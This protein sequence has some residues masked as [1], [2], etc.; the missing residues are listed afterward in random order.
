[1]K[2]LRS[3]L[4]FVNK[5][6]NQFRRFCKRQQFVVFSVAL[7]LFF[8]Q[9]HAATLKG[10]V[11]DVNTREGLVGALVLINDSAR[12]NDITGLDGS[13]VLHNLHPG[14]YSI[15]VQYIGFSKLEQ[16]LH[17]NSETDNL[18]LDILLHQDS[19]TLQQV[20]IIGQVDRESDDF[21]RQSEKNSDN[22][23]N[24]MSAK[25]MQLSPDVTVGNVL[26]RVSGVTVEK[27]SSGEGR[28]A[29]IRGMDKRYNYT[30]INGVKIPSPDNKNRFV[31]MDIFPSEILERLEVIKS[32]AASMEGDAIGGAMNLVLKDAP[33][34][35]LLSANA[36]TGYN[37][38]LFDRSF[39]EFNTSVIHNQS[40]DQLYG[41]QYQAVNSDF[42]L[43]NY[44]YR[45]V[46]ALPNL[47][48]GV[49]IGNRFFHHK[50]GVL[51]SGNY[52]NSYSGTTS[53]FIA[54][55]AQPTF[56]PANGPAFSDIEARTYSLQQQRA[57]LHTKL[58][59]EISSGHK[60]SLYAL[61]VGLDQIRHR[62]ISDTIGIGNP[63]AEVDQHDESKVTYQNILNTSLHGEDSLLRNLQ[64]DWSLNW[65]KATANSPDWGT[66]TATGIAN[67][68]QSTWSSFTR[69]WISNSDRDLSAFFNLT[70]KLK[71]LQQNLELKGGWMDRNKARDNYYDSYD[72]AFAP[73]QLVGNI[74]RAIYS[75][76]NPLGSSQ[77]PNN[78]WLQEN[79][80]AWY[81]Q[82]KFSIGSRIEV[83]G[84]IRTENTAQVYVTNEP[85]TIPGQNGSKRYSDLLPSWSIKYALSNK[86]NLRFSYFASVSRPNYF[87]IVPYTITGEYFDEEGNPYLKHTQADNYDLRYELFPKPSEQVL[88]GVFYKNITDPIEYAFDRVAISTL[89]LKPENF[90]N[91]TNYGFEFVAT[92]YIKRF[93]ISAN[94]TYTKSQ[95]TTDKELY[96]SD[97][98]LGNTNKT[99]SETRPLQGQADHI[100]NLSLIY[101]EPRIG[102]EAQVSLVYTGKLISQV[103]PDYG[104]DYWQMPMIRLDLSFEKKLSRKVNLSVFGKV[105]NILN[106]PLVVR[107]MQPNPLTKGGAYFLPGQDDPNSI[108]VEKEYYGQS[109]M[110]GLRYKFQ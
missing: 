22:V 95:I 105:N 69:R 50:L 62:H 82:L 110:L 86:Q 46:N 101:K 36:G 96:Y 26:Q 30:L 18:T 102:T 23:M 91:A 37:Q 93:G 35:F 99:V 74:N 58:D 29:I 27:T 42:P 5:R 39:S 52:Q 68:T 75:V 63:N 25:T 77:D 59:Y 33:D 12:H 103:S 13:F 47:G 64:A 78:Y 65:A 3:V 94:Y 61:Y 43:Q 71:F 20:T 51:V 56:S 49:T 55:A 38:T 1:M 81:G 106:T 84:G 109:Y 89:D 92:K 19:L 70:Y 11:L 2:I 9:G 97:P 79:I 17:V 88:V 73:N 28:Y 44:E 98:V 32:L 21:A 14:T 48:A 54:P 24:I 45:K 57:A 100:A 7:F 8:T 60:I 34:K 6:G 41:H 15:T 10:H 104:L 4:E 76:S 66:L 80:N 40:P 90:G 72:L 16:S 108:V 67:S 87:E 31:P 83:L 107:V 85:N 53:L